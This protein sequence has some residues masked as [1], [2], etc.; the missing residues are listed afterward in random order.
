MTEIFKCPNCGSNF[1][2]H[3]KIEIFARDEDAEKGIH[4]IIDN[5][6]PNVGRSDI[7]PTMTIKTDDDVSLSPGRR[8]AIIITF[9]CE[10]C[11]KES[12]ITIMQ[13][14]GET[15]IYRQ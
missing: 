14:K 9:W 2:H 11:S 13:R 1:T 4:T 5:I 7:E 6:D 10:G 12:R 8:G 3:N 15:E